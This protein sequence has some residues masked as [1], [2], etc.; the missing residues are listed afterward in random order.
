MRTYKHGSKG[1]RHE[2]HVTTPRLNWLGVKSEDIFRGSLAPPSLEASSQAES[3]SYSSQSTNDSQPSSSRPDSSSR[4]NVFSPTRL[5]G[6]G[7][8]TAN[9]REFATRLLRDL[10]N[11]HDQ[12]AE[13]R[14][15]TRELQLMLMMDLKF[16]IQAVAGS[17]INWLDERLSSGLGWNLR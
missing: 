13:D 11:Q 10:H 5:A 7:R 3:Q 17:L 1:L 15:L 12:D 14:E 2:E 16:H 9:D 8:L 4:W 6:C